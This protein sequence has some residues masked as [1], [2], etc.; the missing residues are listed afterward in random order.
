MSEAIAQGRVWRA[1]L[2]A[3]LLSV[4]VL[5]ILAT[6]SFQT[7]II[8]L[9]VVGVV[10]AA[11]FCF[12]W[13]PLA[14]RALRHHRREVS[15]VR[16]IDYAGV[17]L[18]ILLAFGLVLRNILV[19]GVNPAPDALSAAGRLLLPIT[20]DFVLLLRLGKWSRRLWENYRDPQVD[21]AALEH[22]EREAR[23]PIVEG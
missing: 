19:Y 5:V 14:F 4:V 10:S 7:I 21:S 20:I 15:L 9:Y 17:Q 11:I 3:V 8:S 18:A 22:V 1:V 2:W 6:L 12:T 13:Y 23:D 16:I